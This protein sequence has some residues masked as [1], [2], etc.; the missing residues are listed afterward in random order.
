[1]KKML[2]IF[3]LSFT[4]LYAS[5]YTFL[6]KWNEFEGDCVRKL[7]GSINNQTSYVSGIKKEN[8]LNNRLISFGEQIGEVGQQKFRVNSEK[9]YFTFWIYDKFVDQDMN[10][11]SNQLS[12]S[13]PMVEIYKDNNLIKS[14]KITKKEGLVAK[15]FSLDISNNS[16]QIYNDFYPK[17][18][19]FTGQIVNATNNTL[20]ANVNIQL[21]DSIKK[22]DYII[23]DNNGKF[24]FIPEIGKY[25]IKLN[26][27]GYIPFTT[28]I[29]MNPDET[30]QEFK[31]A[32]SPKTDKIRIVLTWNH[33][34]YDLDAHLR[35]PKPNGGNFHIWYRNKI[36]I[37][38][39]NFL[40]VDDQNGWGPETITIY[41]PA[42]GK[43]SYFVH[44]Y[45]DKD[46]SNSASLSYSNA[47]VSVYKDRRLVKTFSV[48]VNK[49][50]TV[51]HVFDV[52]ELKNII[53][54]NSFEFTTNEKNIH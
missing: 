5:N 4:L 12:S 19:L 28:Y 33:T 8:K 52:D 27:K 38:G 32:L 6:L 29:K 15:I 40:D 14:I 50:G 24:N 36:L 54:V 51:W 49:V 37:D 22:E 2:I 43:Y 45:S 47:K 46:M 53:P 48:P 25:K 7:I 1:M 44:N 35:G 11:D 17:M 41:K 34:P 21:I 9:G 26:K 30:P 42:K 3:F 20:L 13:N 23:S 18:R 31:F 16:I 39:K 10:E